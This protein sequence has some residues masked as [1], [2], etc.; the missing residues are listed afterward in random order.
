[1]IN[2]TL[3]NAAIRARAETLVVTT[4]GSATLSATATGYARV[5]G[6]F[7]TDGFVAGME[8]VPTGFTQTDAGVVTAVSALALTISGGRT[9]QASAAGRSLATGLPA[10]RVYDNRKGAPTVLR[11][12][13]TNELVQGATQIKT[14]PTSRGRFQEEWLSIWTFY[15]IAGTGDAALFAWVG[16]FKALFAPGTTITMTDSTTARV[17]GDVAPKNGQILPVDGGWARCTVTIPLRSS[18]ANVIAA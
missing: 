8:V 9:A 18:T 5:A 13:V 3:L 14:W 1:M 6:S 17:R 10:I 16:A 15:G 2:Q 7:V 12:Y 4:T 11:P